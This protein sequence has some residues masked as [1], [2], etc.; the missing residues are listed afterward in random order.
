MNI[1][2][3]S[4]LRIETSEM[5]DLVLVPFLL[6]LNKL[7]HI[8]QLYSLLIPKNVFPT[9]T[10]LYPWLVNSLYVAFTLPL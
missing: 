6:T 5:L 4:K 7:Q 3:F 10:T 1:L 2:D 8:A 9:G